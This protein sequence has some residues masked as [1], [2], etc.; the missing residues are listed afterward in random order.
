MRKSFHPIIVSL[1][2]TLIVAAPS[3]LSGDLLIIDDQF[4]SASPFGPLQF[5]RGNDPVSSPGQIVDILNMGNQNEPDSQSD[6]ITAGD[7]WSAYDAGGISSIS[8]LVVSMG[9]NETGGV[10][11]NSVDL[12]AFRLTIQDPNNNAN[13]ITDV[14]MDFGGDNTVRVFNFAQGQHTGE[15]DLAVNLG[16]DFMSTF[17]AGSTEL[18]TLAVTV[19]N[20]SDGF[21]IFFFD[22]AA[23]I[24]EPAALTLTSLL[25]LVFLARRRHRSHV[26]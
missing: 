18:I 23:Q 17:N 16:F 22:S 19:T 12:E 25:G 20:R 15:A 2:L 6:T 13:D 5:V 10:G 26:C 24:P 14:D 11:S 7:L 9:I 1:T 4:D 3:L 8:F 21:E